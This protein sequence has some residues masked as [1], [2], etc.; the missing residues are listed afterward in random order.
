MGPRTRSRSQRSS[1]PSPGPDDSLEAAIVDAGEKSKLASVLFPL[2]T[3]ALHPF[4]QALQRSTAPASPARRKVA[5]EG[6]TRPRAQSF[7]ATAPSPGRSSSTSSIKRNGSA[8]R[9]DRLDRL[10]AER[11]GDVHGLPLRP[12]KLWKGKG[13]NREVPRSFSS[14]RAAISAAW[15]LRRHLKKEQPKASDV[16]ATSESLSRNRLRPRCDVALRRATACRPRP[17]FLPRPEK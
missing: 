7:A 12:V 5:A 2:R 11:R 8:M 13:G 1:G 10:A 3:A 15:G 4:V 16:H 9:K 17:R 6:T 14:A